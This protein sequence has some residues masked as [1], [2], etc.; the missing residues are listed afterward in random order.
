MYEYRSII[1]RLQQGQ[2]I[3]SIHR[4]GIAGREKIR[5]V[6]AIAKQNGWLEP[7]CSLP[8][9]NS[10]VAL[11]SKIPK[12]GPIGSLSK[13][14]PFKGL[15][16]TWMAQGVQGSTIY[17]HLRTNHGFS[18]SY[19]SIQRCIRSLKGPDV[20]LTIPLHFQPGEAAQVDFGKGPLLLD[21]RTGKEERTW[22]FV[23]TLCWSRHQF[24]ELVI[25]QDVETWLNCH[26]NAFNW[27]SGVVC[28]IIIDNPKCGIIKAN[29]YEPEVQRSYEAFS[30]TYGFLISACPPRDPQK[31]GRVESGVKY[32][33]KNFMPLRTLTSLQ[34]ANRQLQEWVLSIAGNRVHGSVFEKPLSR[35][36]EIEKFLLKPLPAT[37]PEIAIWRKV[38]LYRNCH[39]LFHKCF[40]SSP[41]T[42]Y[43]QELWLKKT[44]TTITIYHNH[45]AVSQHPRLF[46]EGTYSTLLEHLPQKSQ[47]YMKAT[48]EWCLEHGKTL[49]PSVEKV[50]QKLLSHTTQ[51]LLRAAQGVI[52]LAQTYG[53][54]RLERACQRVLHF[55]AIS[56]GTLKSILT[57]GL[58]YESLEEEKAFDDLGK[59]YQG[60]GVFQ[61]VQSKNIH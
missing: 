25:H 7:G 41:H 12:T 36:M 38:N 45:T 18:G 30:E 47:A 9:E 23:M 16:Q 13:A 43:G 32:V 58:D 28:K 6:Q 1:Y 39:I 49:G 56:Y 37:A 20:E 52:G 44:A 8:E 34:D 55:N 27:F 33:K 61:R 10:L 40:Y 3:R 53:P 59:A 48:P 14:E 54:K 31:K 5:A 57:N 42:L 19:D 24:V 35:F 60:Q 46:K 51:D 2:S 15:I 21:E 17:N 4:D 22:F 26:Q 11:F 50:V 29:Y